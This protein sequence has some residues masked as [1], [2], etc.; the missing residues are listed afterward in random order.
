MSA[1]DWDFT[2]K[3]RGLVPAI[4]PKRDVVVADGDQL[5]LGDTTLSIHLIPLPEGAKRSWR[6]QSVKARPR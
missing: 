6:D 4:K 3:S 1:A 2:E 5:T